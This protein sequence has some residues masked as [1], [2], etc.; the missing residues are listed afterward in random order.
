MNS[1][2]I[3][4]KCGD[5]DCNRKLVVTCYDLDPLVCIEIKDQHSHEIY[6]DQNDIPKL[7]AILNEKM[8]KSCEK[9][10]IEPVNISGP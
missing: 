9:A 1:K 2:S 6:I 5:D 10:D 8:V 7:L 3:D 4:C